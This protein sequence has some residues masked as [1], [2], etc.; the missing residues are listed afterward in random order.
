[1]IA[2]GPILSA[3]LPYAIPAVAYVVGHIVGWFHHKL[4]HPVTTTGTANTQVKP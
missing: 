3:V 4:T 2:V 1:M